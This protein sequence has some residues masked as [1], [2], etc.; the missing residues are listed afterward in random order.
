[1]KKVLFIA[2]IL[3]FYHAHS[4]ELDTIT[5][6]LC[7]EQA[8]K[9]YPVVKQND[10]MDDALAYKQKNLA[11]TYYPHLNINGQ[12]SYQSEVTMVEMNIP[13]N[14]FF[15]SADI[16]PAPVSKD[17]Y[18]L[19]LDISQVIYDG[20][21]TSRQKDVEITNHNMDKQ[22]I[23]VELY[24]LRERVDDIYFGILVL[25]EN[26][27]IIQVIKK[28]INSKLERVESG[29]RNGMLLSSEADILKA[30]II[31]IDQQIIEIK[32]DIQ[33][34]IKMLR[35]LTG[36]EIQD[37]AFLVLSDISIDPY[38]YEISRPEYSLLSLQ[39]DRLKAMEGVISTKDRPR[40]LGFGQAGIGRP[41]LNMLSNTF[42]PFY[43]FGVRLSWNV[44]D[45]NQ[46][47]NERQ[48]LGIQH[49]IIDT[50][51]ETFEKNLS[52]A[53]ERCRGN[54][55]KYE[56]LIKQDD[57]II[58]LRSNIS[59]A[60]SSQLDNGVITAADYL[61]YLNAESQARLNK[62]VHKIFLIKARINYLSSQGKF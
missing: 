54:I 17:W 10:L 28:D 2:V 24:N 42:D 20:G 21:T 48:I 7:R 18:K 34:S 19:T 23:A 27:K 41:G 11:A 15:S 33:S 22:G 9:N 56:E 61:T 37:D 25:Q 38:E 40:F 57:T 52:V 14:P 8:E 35:D 46:T 58:K 31:K 47:R 43:I 32:A 53:L 12:I 60:G 49:D 44:W 29:V 1:M 4:Q 62:E 30:E 45:W 50:Q 55:L 51:K 6:K 16:A 36:L 39:Q 3:I 5:L 59:Q 26:Y 13:P